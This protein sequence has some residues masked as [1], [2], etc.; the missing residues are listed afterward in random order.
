MTKFHGFLYNYPAI[1]NLN[2]MEDE[3]HY[4]DESIFLG[5]V[6][7]S[8][9]VTPQ[10][11]IYENER[12]C[13]VFIGAIYN[14]KELQTRLEDSGY[15]FATTSTTEVLLNLYQEEKEKM[16]T[17]LR[18]MFSLLIWD[19]VERELFGA[20]DRFGIKPFFYTES[21]S[22]LSVAGEVKYLVD[23]ETCELNEEGLHHYLTYQYVPEPQVMKQGIK[24]LEPGHYFTKKPNEPMNITTYW[25]PNFQPNEQATG[26]PLKEIRDTLRDSVH[27]HLQTDRKIG[28]FL[29][30]GV[31]SSAVV[32]L[33][34]EIHPTI[35]TFTVGFEREGYS[36]IDIAK[37]TAAQL[38]VDNHHYVV[39]IDEFVSE[40]PKIIEEMETPLADPA[41][42]PLYFI[43][44]EA[45]KHVDVILSGEG[46]DELFGGYNIYREPSS[47][48]M[49]QYVPKS[50]HA[51][52]N[53][54]ASKLPEGTK[55]KSFIDRGTTPLE[56]R[57]IGNAKLFG[58][59]EKA[60]LLRNYHA[61]YD[62]R[63]ITA[64]LYKEVT[65]YPDVQK[66]QYIDLHT[67]V[68]GDILLKANRMT[69]AHGLEIR[70][71]FMDL[72]V[73]NVASKLTPEQCVT[74]ETTKYAMREAVRG[75][76]PDSVLYNRK[77]GFPVPIRY[78][79]KNELFDWAK[80][81]IEESKVDDLFNKDY[82][83]GL[84]EAHREG[85]IDYSRKIWAILVFII[86]HEQAME[87]EEKEEEPLSEMLS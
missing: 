61:E 5:Y 45:K 42:I 73:F 4:R 63:N 66:M 84:L 49:F 75:I 80:Q 24:R 18:G 48:K 16:L 33:A 69:A 11:R 62:H 23:S 19:K 54:L 51:T 12:Y 14:K 67:W 31:D 82:A 37:E 74:K 70:S 20:R 76:V 30:G 21:E 8:N 7:L 2:K 9:E 81:L 86:W 72:E 35:Q 85:K 55:G 10:E 71:P 68:R 64:P 34:K 15:S 29:S 47:L 44:R 57:F 38:G 22:G 39:G 56:D 32:A 28:A 43:S 27:A 53:Q 26:A 77:L 50:M 58:E 41:A 3:F 52:L 36:E 46:A 1:E 25:K 65:H 78:W 87:H 40:L 83:L 6:Q 60:M 17:Q 79:L 13:I 59:S